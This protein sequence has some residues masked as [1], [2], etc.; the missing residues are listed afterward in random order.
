MISSSSSSSS[1]SLSLSLSLPLCL[2]GSVAFTVK[3]LFSLSL[4]LSLSWEICGGRVGRGGGGGEGRI[5]TVRHSTLQSIAVPHQDLQILPPL[6]L[7]PTRAA[8]CRSR[9]EE[10]QPVLSPG[11]EEGG[12]GGGGGGGV[13]L[14][15]Q[16]FTFTAPPKPWK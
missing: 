8:E 16:V 14:G 6:I 12:S 2:Y 9:K 13:S 3:F 10:K 4:S 1:L 7:C 5:S 15:S 11:M